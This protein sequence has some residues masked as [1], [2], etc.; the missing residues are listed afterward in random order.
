[1]KNDGIEKL[2][3]FVL[4]ALKKGDE[5]LEDMSM[6][7]ELHCLVQTSLIHHAPAFFSAFTCLI[8]VGNDFETRSSTV[9]SSVD[10]LRTFES[11]ENSS[12]IISLIL[13]LMN[14]WSEL[15]W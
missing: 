13:S 3:L 6:I 15:R 14:Y 7:D 8:A 1:M 11:R 5:K 2:R 10:T 12:E 4:L 9:D